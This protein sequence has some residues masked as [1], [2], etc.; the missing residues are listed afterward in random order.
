MANQRFIKGF[1]KGM[2]TGFKSALKKDTETRAEVIDDEL[3]DIRKSINDTK[4]KSG[5][6]PTKEHVLLKRRMFELYSERYPNVFGDKEVVSIDEVLARYDEGLKDDPD[7][8]ENEST[9]GIKQI[10]KKQKSLDLD[11]KQAIAEVKATKEANIANAKVEIASKKDAL[12]IITADVKRQHQT[13]DGLNDMFQGLLGTLSK[14]K[15]EAIKSGEQSIWEN[16]STIKGKAQVGTLEGRYPPEV[17]A[18]IMQYGPDVKYVDGNFVSGTLTESIDETHAQYKELTGINITD[19][20][21]IDEE[22]LNKEFYKAEYMK[23]GIDIGE[24]PIDKDY[25]YIDIEGVE[26]TLGAFSP[27]SW[28]AQDDMIV[29]QYIKDLSESSIR[30]KYEILMNNLNQQLQDLSESIYYRNVK[31]KELGE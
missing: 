11:M 29:A 20:E 22:S 31:K 1:Q 14:D 15:Q 23:Q 7:T 21:S 19:M 16:I 3:S 6:T 26:Q 18:Q 17:I 10:S 4:P 27:D 25:T 8:P 13:K 9:L 28:D 30:Y 24:I 12:N 5:E 2:E